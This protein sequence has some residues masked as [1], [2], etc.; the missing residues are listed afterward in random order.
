MYAGYWYPL[1]GIHLHFSSKAF[2]LRLYLDLFTTYNIHSSDYRYSSNTG[3]IACPE[4]P[5]SCPAPPEWFPDLK[6]P[7][8]KPKGPRQLVGPYAWTREFEHASVRLDLFNRNA[9][10]VT[11]H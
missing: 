8:G 2:H 9:S 5:S 3:Y 10:K 11:Y 6:K 7:L 4:A 1:R